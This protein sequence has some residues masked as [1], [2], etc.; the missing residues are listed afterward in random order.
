MDIRY[1]NHPEDVKKYDTRELRK[2]FLIEDI[3]QSDKI[4]LL[5]QI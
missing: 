5:I 1:A 3:F 2:H 4:I